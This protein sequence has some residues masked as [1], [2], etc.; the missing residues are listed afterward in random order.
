MF[1]IPAEMTSQIIYQGF[2]VGFL[3]AIP[4]GPMGMICVQRTLSQ[5]RLAGMISATGLTLAAAFW[6]VVAAQGLS[7]V[8]SFVSGHETSAMVVLGGFLVAAGIGGLM[9]GRRKACGTSFNACGTMAG[10]FVT[11]LVGVLLNPITFV[12]MTAVLAVLG[13]VQK[14]P[15][16]Q[17]LTW[18]AAAVF[19]GGMVLWVAITQGVTLLRNRLGESG[20]LRISQALNGCILVLGI[21]YLVRPLLPQLAG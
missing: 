7:V 9:K 15:G 13:G 6:C 19:M 16:V 8:A 4:L 1:P 12:T 21:I 18:L 11:S 2:A 3:A 20:G 10:H 14:N 5:G 17:G